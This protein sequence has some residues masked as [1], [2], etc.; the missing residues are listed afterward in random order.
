[1]SKVFTFAILA[2]GLMLISALMGIVEPSSIFSFFGI[3]TT[4]LD[5]S[6]SRIYEI[7]QD[8]ILLIGAVAGAIVVGLFTRASPESYIVGLF[9]AELLAFIGSFVS[10][11]NSINT[12]TSGDWGAKLM[13]IIMGPIIIG[14]FIALVSYWRGAD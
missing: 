6:N 8:N 7:I 3:S 9:C 2:A 12:S 1:M 11:Y 4:S 13:L 14:F 5:S 10:I